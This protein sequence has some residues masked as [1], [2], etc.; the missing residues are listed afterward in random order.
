[1][2]A[3]D[4][5]E[6]GRMDSG[7]GAIVERLTRLSDEE[8]ASEATAS[9]CVGLQRE[10]DDEAI[11]PDG[12][13][14]DDRRALQAVALTWWRRRT[15]KVAAPETGAI[16][17]LLA[18]AYD[19]DDPSL[20]AD[21]AEVLTRFADH[22]E[23]AS[24]RPIRQAALAV[25][26]LQR[27]LHADDRAALDTAVAALRDAVGALPP[28]RHR[29]S[30]L[31]NLGIALRE[32]YGRSQQEPDIT[33]A[34]EAHEGAIAG[35]ASADPALAGRVA[36]LGHAW[37]EHY[38]W[39]GDDDSLKAAVRAH[40]LALVQAA[41]AHPNGRAV[42]L[43]YAGSLRKRAIRDG[44]VRRL[45][46]VG[47]VLETLIGV[48]GDDDESAA[49]RADAATT[50]TARYQLTGAVD[51]ITAA[52]DWLVAAIDL[53]ATAP[54]VVTY[55]GN[56]GSALLTRY[57]AG[58]DPDDL[59]AAG[60]Q[61]ELSIEAR[62]GD[63]DE[64]L[65]R[66]TLAL[67][68]L[69]Q[70]ER[71]GDVDL[72]AEAIAVTRTVVDRLA[73]DQ[74]DRPGMLANLAALLYTRYERFGE[75][76]DLDDAVEFAGRSAQCTPQRNA[77]RPGR[78]ANL[79]AA[80]RARYV[81]RLDPEDL[82]EAV[83]ILWPVVGLPNAESAACG[84]TLGSTLLLRADAVTEGR[85][86]DLDDA[87]RVLAAVVEASPASQPDWAGYAAEYGRAL[88]ARQQHRRADDQDGADEDL[89]TAVTVLTQAAGA[90]AVGN[91]M[92][93]ACLMNLA[94]AHRAAFRATDDDSSFDQAIA[95]YA[96]ACSERGGAAR[97]RYQAA[98]SGA[99]LAMLRER[100]TVALSAF[101]SAV[102]LLPRMAWPGLQRGQQERIL[103]A[104]GMVV[105]DAAVV[106]IRLGRYGLAL[107]LLEQ[108]RGVLWA[109]QT[110]AHDDLTALRAA[111][112]RLADEL[113][114]VLSGL[115][116]GSPGMRDTAAEGVPGGTADADR[117][118]QLSVRLAEILAQIRQ[119]D[120]FADFWAAPTA[121]RLLQ[122]A[123]QGPVVLPVVSRYGSHA[124]V[125]RDG[126]PIRPVA[127]TALQPDD[128]ID[129]SL[130]YARVLTALRTSDAAQRRVATGQLDSVLAWLWRS[131]AKP[132]LSSLELKPVD[133]QQTRLW[134]CPIGLLALM[135]LHAA[136][137]FDQE[138]LADIGVQDYVINSY[139]PT[140]RDLAVARRRVTEPVTAA[141]AVA[142]RRT[143][144]Q[145]ELRHVAAEI[146]AIRAALPVPVEVI[147]DE[148]ATLDRVRDLL[149]SVQWLHFAGHSRQDLDVPGDSCLLLADENLTA[150][151][152]GAAGLPRAQLTFLASCESSVGSPALPDEALH[153]A[154]A[155]LVA[156]CSHVISTRWAVPDSVAAEL[157]GAVYQ[158]LCDGD[159]TVAAER[160]ATAL[161]EALRPIRRSHPA[162]RW[163]AYCHTGR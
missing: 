40:R 104:E 136:Q 72:L 32:R 130:R 124:L 99:R 2:P 80:L 12:R 129:H 56:L 21:V 154:G 67:V 77:H 61:L 137:Y 91:P 98:V 9:L 66:G 111:Y 5:D 24:A 13:L 27:A 41:L 159:G 100:E 34:I 69:R 73:A 148:D 19:V 48:G 59:D 146:A 141:V 74:P 135:P 54:A 26:L 144:G 6:M 120:N 149:A 103:A 122:V 162:V 20:P 127:L 121:D 45:D 57:V 114:V 160:A 109:Q 157:T 152:I 92:R 158:K 49:I 33:A 63:L 11:R 86:R 96:E 7:R 38:D 126:E 76:A 102:A 47:D 145:P 79:A 17:G 43:G 163:A 108:G 51:D 115:D 132:V 134:W 3:G 116:S 36:M 23:V 133:R 18:A 1:M 55:R 28:G 119:D 131:V 30:A 106:A 101:E 153:L 52:I 155:L 8:V 128:L 94:V 110:R 161:H 93:A 75:P 22:P 58:G 83:R 39:T 90:L 65:R 37:E 107:R 105:A 15:L 53:A 151:G 85:G 35:S 156:G 140:L 87:V 125:L 143:P 81:L 70:F 14:A 60:V 142:L 62:S 64:L 138:T 95:R 112:P 42:A 84:A 16:V 89:A 113:R 150:A 82:D 123:A 71:T 78:I 44:D 4:S 25:D 118:V 46:E 97:V 88:L 139:T 31:G 117:R 50:A 147:A 68:W 10:L 29:T